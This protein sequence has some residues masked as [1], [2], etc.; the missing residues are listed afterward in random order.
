MRASVAKANNEA[1]SNRLMSA[2][3]QSVAQVVVSAVESDR[4]RTRYLLTPAARF[5]AATHSVAGDR[6]WDRLMARQFGL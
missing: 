4:P 5:M 2:S 1:Y 3:A 6:V